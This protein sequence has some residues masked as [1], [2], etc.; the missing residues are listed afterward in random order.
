MPVL[1]WIT[2]QRKLAMNHKQFKEILD[3]TISWCDQVNTL[4][5]AREVFQIQNTGKDT[6][7]IYN[8]HAEVTNEFADCIVQRLR[9][10]NVTDQSIVEIY[11]NYQ[12]YLNMDGTIS[13]EEYGTANTIDELAAK[14]EARKDTEN[15]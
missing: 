3:Y 15:E 10:L 7:K 8:H 5:S 13:S 1:I 9:Q 14:I 6:I 12:P 4:K 11:R 2:G